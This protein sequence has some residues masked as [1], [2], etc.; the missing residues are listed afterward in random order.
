[1]IT[2]L[3]EEE[4][5]KEWLSSGTLNSLVGWLFQMSNIWRTTIN[6]IY[7]QLKIYV[8]SCY[9][10]YQWALRHLDGLFSSPHTLDQQV[11]CTCHYFF[12]REIV[13][14]ISVSQMFPLS[15]LLEIY[16]DWLLALSWSVVKIVEALIFYGLIINFDLWSA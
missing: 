15:K 14:W 10:L 1:M 2:E 8:I 4:D 11:C 9:W 16:H 12:T 7:A 5:C 3:D 6:V 13:W